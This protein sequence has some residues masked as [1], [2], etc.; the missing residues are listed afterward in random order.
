MLLV[1]PQIGEQ[2][3]VV[4]ASRHIV[5]VWFEHRGVIMSIPVSVATRKTTIQTTAELPA[6]SNHTRYHRHR[7]TIR[8][9]KQE[10]D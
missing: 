9:H 6:V 8:G 10:W 7:G 4:I 3:V 5:G 2:D 1:S